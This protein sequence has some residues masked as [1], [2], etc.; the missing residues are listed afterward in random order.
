MN[1]EILR[2]DIEIS[3]VSLYIVITESCRSQRKTLRNQEFRDLKHRD[4]KVPPVYHFR[5]MQAGQLFPYN[6]V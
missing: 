2:L 1:F 4:T 5:T 3:R 6:Q